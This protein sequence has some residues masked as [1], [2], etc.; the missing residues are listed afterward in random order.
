MRKIIHVDMDAFYASIEQ[1]EDPS[2]KGKALVVGGSPDGRGV[3]AAASYEARKFGIRSAMSAAQAIKLCPEAI[4]VRPRIG[5]YKQVSRV[6]MGCM[7]Q[8][9][10]AVE[11]LSL[12][13]AYLDV[14]ENKAGLASATETAELLRKE[15]FLQ[16]SLTAS[17]GVAPNKFLAKVASDMNKPD[18]ITVIKPAMVETLLKT[19]P[20]RKVPGIGKVTERKMHGLG[21]KT[22]GDLQLRSE[23]ELIS[24][25]GKTGRWYYSIA[26]GIDTRAVNSSRIRKSI[27]TEDT[28]ETDSTDIAWLNDKI[29][30]LSEK[31]ARSL[32][33]LDTSGRTIQLKVTYG[34]FVKVTRSKTLEQSIADPASISE[35]CQSLLTETEAG[36]RPIRLLGVGMSK[37]DLEPA[38][39]VDNSG[40]KQL[41]FDFE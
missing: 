25:F 14:T 19:L 4:F 33:R 16:T 18:G 39:V 17:A 2:L 11:P 24:L 34:D 38:K 22:T 7:N 31:V 20:V 40:P 9:A 32:L 21:I 8:F 30:E 28:F 6:I 5:F 15:I 26:R 1:R 3:V 10:D 37:L 36:E 12:D 35:I 23:E 13:E 41:T 29:L 27:S